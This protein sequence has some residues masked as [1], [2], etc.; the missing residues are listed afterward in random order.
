MTSSD[1]WLERPQAKKGAAGEA[2][3]DAFLASRRVVPYA[4]IAR[5]AHP[6]DRLCATA[7]KRTI[8]VAEVKTKARRNKYPDTGISKRH[9]QDYTHVCGKY[10]LRVYLFFVDE[11]LKQI[12]GNWLHVLERPR[13][14]EH[15]GSAIHYPW[16]WGEIVYFP[17]A[18]MEFVCPLNSE[19][20]EHLKA[21]S[22]RS[23]EYQTDAG[24]AP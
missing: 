4:P 16:D 18:A 3:V 5:G 2:L 17:L 19:R 14:I 21:L 22:T 24:V 8:F 23:Y 20:S 11:M 9:Y 10:G 12:Y 6:F 7:D 15:N 13:E 1:L